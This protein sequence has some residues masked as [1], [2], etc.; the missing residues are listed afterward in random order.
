V[1]I[2]RRAIAGVLAAAIALGVSAAGW[3]ASGF[4]D[5]RASAIGASAGVGETLLLVVADVVAGEE[6]GAKL[7]DLNGSFGDVQGF[8]A[9]ATDGY[10]VLGALVQVSPDTATIRCGDAPGSETASLAELA[11]TADCS[12]ARAPV[13]ALLPITTTLVPSREV[14]AYLSTIPCGTPELPPCVKGRF[15][16][17]MGPDLQLDPGQVVLTTAFRT[18][19]GAEE[20]LE[21]ARAVGLTGLITVQARKLAGGDVGLGQEPHPDGSGPLTGPLPDQLEWQR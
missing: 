1:I 19:R 14:S 3:R 11:S 4:T 15:D 17:L 6:S 2:R 16:D 18:K 10:E 20:F 5:E 21:L 12:D 13:R 9:D 8:Y 7:A